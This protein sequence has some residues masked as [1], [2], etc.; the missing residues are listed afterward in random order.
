MI[1]VDGLGL[2]QISGGSQG[3][4]SAERSLVFW[5]ASISICAD[6]SVKLAIRLGSMRVDHFQDPATSTPCPGLPSSKLANG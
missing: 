2:A 4:K 3:G 6:P 1:L 5:R